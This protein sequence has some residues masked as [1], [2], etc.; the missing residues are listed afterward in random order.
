MTRA[1]AYI[2]FMQE[3]E[4]LRVISALANPSR[5]RTL[6]LLA[7]AGAIGMASSDIADTLGLPRNL[8]S[9]HLA[10]LS[11]AGVVSPKKTGRSVIYMIKE[12]TII[13]LATYLGALTG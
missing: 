9:S 4:A 3:A 7:R 5:L 8:M 12:D 10:V 2:G 11:R 13:K 6:A 1:C